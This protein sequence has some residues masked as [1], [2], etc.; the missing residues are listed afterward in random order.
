MA[1]TQ[2]Q[3]PTTHGCANLAQRADVRSGDEQLV[4]TF[5]DG[6][7]ESSQAAFREIV[8]RHGPMI[9]GVCRHALQNEHDAEDAFQATFLTLLRKAGTIRHPGML[10]NW[11]YEVAFRIAIRTRARGARRRAQEGQGAAL[12][13]EA[14]MPTQE[15]T[16]ASG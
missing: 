10:S 9:M 16:V 13:S 8:A 11:L 15:K 3:R 2:T 5:L 4:L 7:D 14:T 1:T 12:K 6:H